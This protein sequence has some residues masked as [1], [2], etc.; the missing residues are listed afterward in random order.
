[1]LCHSAFFEVKIKKYPNGVVF[2]GIAMSKACSNSNISFVVE[3]TP[4]QK[5]TFFNK[6]FSPL[7]DN[8]LL[9]SKT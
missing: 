6:Y 1:M 5:K 3:I 7:S 8:L 2:R 4:K 9:V